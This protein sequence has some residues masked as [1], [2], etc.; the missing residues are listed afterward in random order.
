M[1][2]LIRKILYFLGLEGISRLVILDSALKA[3]GWF[4][5]VKKKQAVNKNG[6]PIPWVTYPFIDFIDG[7]LNESMDVFEFGAGNSSLYFANRVKSV[8]S[9]EHHPDWFKD[10]STN[11]EYQLD[12]LS[13][14]LVEIPEELSKLGYHKMAFTDNEN[15]YVL[16]LRDSERKYDIVVVDGLFRNTCMKNCI[17]NLSQEEWFFWIIRANT[18]LKI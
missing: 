17:S 3:D 11:K 16:S 13:M 8:T 18:I 6:K 7:R 1:K 15:D 10:I 14:H 9:I 12:N 4:L 2:G 5:S